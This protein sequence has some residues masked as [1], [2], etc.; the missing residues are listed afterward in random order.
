MHALI[1]LGI[2]DSTGAAGEFIP[3][4]GARRKGKLAGEA[5][6]VIYIAIRYI[7]EGV[8]NSRRPSMAFSMVT[9]S[10]Y[11]RSEPTG[12]PTPIRVTRMPS[13]LM[14]FEI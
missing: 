12:M 14:S 1:Q 9:S 5:R 2:R 7:P 6:P 10:A 4:Q 11:S 13:G 8:Y 3:P